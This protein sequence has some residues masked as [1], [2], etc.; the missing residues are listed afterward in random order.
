MSGLDEAR[1]LTAEEHERNT[2]ALD[3]GYLGLTEL[4]AALWSFRHLTSLS[5]AQ[6]PPRHLTSLSDAQSPPRHLTS[7]SD[8][9][10]SASRP[11]DRS[12]EVLGGFRQRGWAAGWVP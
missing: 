9:Q 3:V 4:P 6:S 8:A 5:D 7:L 2:G 1:R 11:S 10:K 12:G